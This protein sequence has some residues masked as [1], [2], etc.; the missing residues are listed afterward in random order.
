VFS[1]SVLKD[2]IEPEPGLLSLRA[3]TLNTCIA[4]ADWKRQIT[5]P[6]TD[7]CLGDP[8]SKVHLIKYAI[9]KH[10]PLEQTR[11]CFSNNKTA[12]GTCFACQKRLRAFENAKIPDPLTYKKKKAKKN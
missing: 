10:I 5:S 7:P 3:Q 1:G 9:K 2:T 12:D 6:L 11:T 8:L 4:L